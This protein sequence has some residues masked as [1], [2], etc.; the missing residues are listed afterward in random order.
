M[1][2]KLSNVVSA[3]APALGN[4]LN[5]ALPGSG[6]VVSSLAALFGGN[7]SNPDDL[8]HK[9]INDPEAS[10]KLLDFQNKHLEEL[11]RIAASD[12]SSA[13][14][15]QIEVTKA[16]GKRDWVMDFLT[17][18]LVVGF[19]SLIMIVA[20]TKMDQS[21]HDILYLLTGQLSGAFLLSISYYFGSSVPAKGN[22]N[23]E[24]KIN[25]VVLPPPEQTR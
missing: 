20:F 1:S 21:D 19:F 14:E 4:V 23:H 3:I 8:A 13:R 2:S 15:R 5:L 12:R 6:L 10:I 9:I 25:D 22:G 16:T 17:I 24:Q 18:F 11:E 7:S